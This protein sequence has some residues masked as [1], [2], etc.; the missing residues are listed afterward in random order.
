[1]SN[2]IVTSVSALTDDN[3]DNISDNDVVCI[4]IEQGFLG[5]HKSNPRYEIDVSGTINC[6]TLKINDIE[7]RLDAEVNFIDIASNMIPSLNNFY[8]IGQSN[9]MWN[10][11]Y[12]NNAYIN[13]LRAPLITDKITTTNR[14]Y[15]EINNNSTWNAVNGYYGLAKH[16][17]PALDPSSSG[18][19]AVATWTPRAVTLTD[20]F[21]I[22]WSPQLGLFVAV[23]NN[24]VMTSN[25]GITWNSIALTSSN[26]RGICWSPERSL[27]VAVAT[28][29]TNRI[30]VSSNGTIWN[31]PQTYEFNDWISVCWSKELNLFAA[32]AYSGRVT[33]SN[34]GNTW[35][36]IVVNI[37]NLRGICWSPELSLFVAVAENQS[38]IL[39]SSDG[40][41]WTT[42]ACPPGAWYSICWSK[43][44]GLFVAVAGDV[45]NKLMTSSNGINW[46]II[47]ID[48]NNWHSVCWSGELGLFVAVCDSGTFRLITSSDGII[49]TRRSVETSFWKGVCWSPELGLFVAV[50][51]GGA[52]SGSGFN[53]V[54]TSSLRGR[55]PTSYNVFDSTFNSIDQRGNWTFAAIDISSNLN[56]ITNLTGTLGSITKIWGNANIRDLSVNNI[57]VS[58]NIIIP[59]N[60]INSSHIQNRTIIGEDI[61]TGTIT[62]ANIA[63]GTITETKLA[64]AVQ[65]KLNAVSEGS[66][67]SFHI[68]NATIS[69]DK[70]TT[71]AISSLQA[72]PLNSIDS[73]HI[74]DDSIIEEKLAL[75][76]QA[77]LNTIG[78]GGGNNGIFEIKNAANS[79]NNI[80][81]SME[82]KGGIG[83][84]TFVFQSIPIGIGE[85]EF[86]SY[87]LPNN[88]ATITY[89]LLVHADSNNLDPNTPY[90]FTQEFPENGIFND[91]MLSSS[92]INFSI[93]RNAHQ[94]LQI[95]LLVT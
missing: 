38:N 92:A 95:E 62:D 72:T 12:L 52:V 42:R 65:I 22:C 30:M 6:N 70:L 5:I 41:N 36:S 71:D 16:A 53:L 32:V 4:D 18:V 45:G 26:L 8:D 2:K 44:L 76:V 3:I 50:A 9:F 81:V 63:I 51:N 40:I 90:S 47:S 24:R 28:S 66:I 48:A 35:T 93:R 84:R 55:P 75:A 56:P 83:G 91:T 74:I 19:K 13:K 78:G 15:Q 85:T 17:Y 61:S 89:N 59:A 54:L 25:N 23:G 10:N 11:A 77:K 82:Y 20:W 39:V 69:Y 87:A 49:W 7:F 60:S 80:Y 14:L 73:S 29:E 34:N 27:F 94:Y 67:T 86:I 46:T 79:S 68:A 88:F 1:M 31:V 64:S 58:G 57:S 43:E 21:N 33:T 37:V